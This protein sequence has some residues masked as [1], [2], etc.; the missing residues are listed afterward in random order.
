MHRQTAFGRRRAGIL[1]HPTS[2]PGPGDNGTLGARAIQFL[3]FLSAAGISVWQTLPLL[4]VNHTLSPYQAFSLFA[5]DVRLIDAGEVI[6]TFE[7]PDHEE[8]PASAG[9]IRA[10]MDCLRTEANTS[11]CHAFQAFCQ[12][13]QY[14][15][16]PWCQFH[17]LRGRFVNA[18][19]T[20]WPVAFRRFEPDPVLPLDPDLTAV[21]NEE[22]FRQFLFHQQWLRLKNEAN[23]RGIALFGDLPFYPSADSADVWQHQQLFELDE[24][25]DPARIAGVPPDAFSTTGQSWG[26]PVYRWNEHKAEGFD[27]W[28]RRLTSQLGLFGILRIDH[29]IGLQACW[30]HPPEVA[31]VSGA[32]SP[33]PGDELLTTLFSRLGPLA[34]VAEDLGHVTLEL[35]AL[36]E[37]FSLPGMRVL[38]FGFDGLPD[39]LHH[40]DRHEPNCV[41]YTG[42]HDNNTILGWWHALSQEEKIR[43]EEALVDDAGPVDEAL[44]WRINRLCL[45]S[46]ALL[47]VLPMQD[48]LGLG[49]EARMNR[50][51]TEEGNW[52]WRLQGGECNTR[53]AS[54]LR[55]LVEAS[56]RGPD[57]AIIH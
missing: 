55:E 20:A 45:D 6:D 13:Q 33:V 9:L 56:D 41:A 14:W 11:L 19:W 5:G 23:A 16:H 39:N 32:W 8:G 40:P 36:Q 53:L 10:A 46:P 44:H 31:P 35:R 15:L 57:T 24:K 4:P 38:Q 48:I 42:T 25:G 49:S 2:L 30:S 47:A 22:A 1:L 34:L 37:K 50:P 43:V 52:S 27:W 28:L 3:D 12:Q 29:F 17:A 21:M 51:G 18:R 7:L 26:A 54:Q